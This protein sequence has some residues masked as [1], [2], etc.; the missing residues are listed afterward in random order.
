[1]EKD[2]YDI[3][4]V[5]SNSTTEEIKRAYH[6]L[7]H[8]YHPD[9]NNGNEKRFKEINEAYRILSNNKTR[10]EYDFKY[11]TEKKS[12]NNSST[13]KTNTAKKEPAQKTSSSYQNEDYSYIKKAIIGAAILI[14]LI[15]SAMNNYIKLKTTNTMDSGS[16][17]ENSDTV[18]NI[19]KNQQERHIR[20]GSESVVKENTEFKTISGVNYGHSIDSLNFHDGYLNL[21]YTEGSYQSVELQLNNNDINDTQVMVQNLKYIDSKGRNYQPV[22]A[23]Y[24]NEVDYKTFG[25]SDSYFLNLKPAIPCKSTVIFEVSTDSSGYW[26]DFDF[27]KI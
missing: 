16:I 2:Y 6:I 4:G 26:I 1:M 10:S 20:L 22:A 19:K 9:K 17:Q 13:E 27:L 14:A 25:A 8:Q 24:C 21:P 12:H 7:A 15:I 5:R 18:D 3:L 11:T 23:K